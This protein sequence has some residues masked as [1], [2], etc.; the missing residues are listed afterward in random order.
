[1]T[2]S[3]DDIFSPERL[4]HHWQQDEVAAG[5]QEQ[6]ELKPDEPEDAMA[7]FR[8]LQSRIEERFPGEQGQP[9]ALLMN[10]L[11]ELLVKRFPQTENVQV[12]DE[13]KASLDPAIEAL[14]NE[15]EDL[16]EAL[17]L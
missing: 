9:L 17:E 8:H 15:I 10:E 13:D 7:V 16:V 11:E 4:R 14:L 1:M 12:T 2:N 6:A 3:L 5:K